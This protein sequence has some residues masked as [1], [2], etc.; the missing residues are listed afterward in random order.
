MDDYDAYHLWLGI[1]PEEQPP[2]HYR[3]LGVRP[4]EENVEVIRNAAD[5]Q[6]SHVKRLGVNDF[7]QLGQDLLNEIE[8]A[9]ICLLRPEKRQAYD[10]KLRAQLP[11]PPPGDNRGTLF[12]E[13]S[14]E[15]ALSEETLI[16]GSDHHCDIVI[17]LPIISGVHCSVMRRQE[18]VI[19]RDLKSTNGTFLNF[20]KVSQP[21]PITPRDLIVLG[22]D[23]RL[24]LPLAFFPP[25]QR[26]PRVSFVGRSEQ[27]EI[28]LNEHTVSAFH[29][30]LLFVAPSLQV[31]DLGSTNG[32][33]LIDSQGQSIRL[34]PR[35][36]T[37]VA[38]F[39]QIAFGKHLLSIA[40]LASYHEAWDPQSTALPGLLPAEEK[41]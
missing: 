38:G 18:K 37:S 15:E 27:C 12:Q 21:S 13:P 16:I 20:T 2:T 39:V 30:R 6:R 34:A 19:L 32:T 9:K 22:R 26:T 14:S 5:R 28:W 29:A 25:D 33:T 24:K 41:P 31:E 35:K 10:E 23:T 17:D 8:A 40:S 4:F 36:P 7:Q 11:P 3:L 1:P